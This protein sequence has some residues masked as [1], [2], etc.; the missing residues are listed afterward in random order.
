MDNNDKLINDGLILVDEK[1]NLYDKKLNSLSEGFNLKT[2][3]KFKFSENGNVINLRTIENISDYARILAFIKLMKKQYDDAVSELLS[4]IQFANL[5]EFEYLGYSYD[6]WVNDIIYL[7]KKKVYSESLSELKRKR[8][9]LSSL[10]SKELKD[11]LE[12][13][14]ILNG[15]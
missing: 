12:I 13:K 1:I 2:N 6:E 7:F 11:F 4:Y 15:L 3:C 8:E 5:E 10:Y 9:R 14:Q